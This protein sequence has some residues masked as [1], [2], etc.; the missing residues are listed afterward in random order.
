[1]RDAVLH[2]LLLS[3]W[4]GA[5]ALGAL[6]VSALLRRVHT[7]SRMLCWLWLAVGLRFALPWGIPLTLP[8]PRNEQLAQAADTVQALT[9]GPAPTPAP[10]IQAPAA[11]AASAAPWYTQLT[12]WHLLVA[13]WA[14]GVL[15]LAVRAVAGYARLRHAVALAC[16]TGDGCYSGDCVPAPFTLGIFRPRIYLPAAL[17]GAARQAVVLHERTHLRRHDPQIKPLFYAVVCLHWFNPLAWLA[18]RQ[19]EREMESACDEA[20]VRD[21][22]AAARNAYCESILQYALQGRMAPGS[23]AFGQ[24]SVKTR[25]VHLLHYRKIGAGALVVCAAAVG[26]SVTACMMQPQVEEA[27]PET[28]ETTQ[29]EPA[30]QSTATPEN[31]VTFS[32]NTAGLPNLDDS[33]NS[34]RFLC[35]VDYTYI[36]RYMDNSHRGDDLAADK[37]APVYAVQDGVVTYADFHYSYGYCVILDHGTGPDGNQWSTLYAHMDDYTVANGQVVKAGELIGHVGSTGNSTGNHLHFE[38]FLNGGVTQPR[39]LTAYREEDT[40]PLT[41]EMAQE[42]LAQAAENQRSSQGLLPL[43]SQTLT[44]T[45]ASLQD[46]LDRLKDRRD[47]LQVSMD[48]LLAGTTDQEKE[49]AENYR[50]QIDLFDQEIQLLE[51]QIQVIQQQLE[52]EQAKEDAQSA[53]AQIQQQIDAAQSSGSAGTDPALYA[54]EEAARQ[55]LDAAAE[56]LDSYFSGSPNQNG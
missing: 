5:A 4:G 31:A 51:D 44:E 1:M 46:Q 7:P 48:T 34:P 3:L 25:I 42:L 52:E 26:L 9:E 16:K 21:C 33:E 24:G 27:T 30:P 17:T 8:R 41:T 39:Y 54:G 36:S 23:L 13:V 47:E 12:V 35:P 28:A 2:F 37:G 49:L 20:A 10:V 40:Q 32:A 56:Q 14:V 19:L 45:R 11:A 38:V 43:E 53:Q 29:S 22:D 15:V 50:Q 6:A 18:F 55:Q